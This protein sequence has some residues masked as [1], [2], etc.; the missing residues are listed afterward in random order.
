V[1]R[2]VLGTALLVVGIVA[3]LGSSSAASAFGRVGVAVLATAVGVFLILGPW[4]VRLWNDLGTE[5]RERIRSEERAEFAAHLHDSVLQTL[6]LIQRH[7]DTPSQTRSL[8]RAQERELRTWLYGARPEADGDST[9][10]L[11]LDAIA[12][13]IESRFEVEVDVVAVGDCPV[14]ERV[15]A[16]LAAVREASVNAARHAGVGEVSV[17]VEVEP[18]R[19]SAYVRDRG[20]GFD[21]AAVPAGRLGVAESIIGRMARHGGRAEVLSSPGDGTEVTLE[22][23]R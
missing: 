9:L 1:L 15:D 19:V 4:M 21:V 10:S 7:A 8:A 3:L 20:V 13:D 16:L 22:V 18:D 2:A 11:A 17:Y 23:P 14:D 6:A 12:S 5:R